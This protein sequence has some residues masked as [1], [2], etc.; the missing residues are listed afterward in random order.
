[1]AESSA[2]VIFA[3][4]SRIWLKGSKMKTKILALC[5]IVL[6]TTV[7]MVSIST[8]SAA[9]GPGDWIT[10]YRIVDASTE[11]LII[12]TESNSG[13]GS[14]I[15]GAQLKVTVTISIPTSSPSTLLNL[16]TAMAHSSEDHFWEHSAS[17][18]YDLGSYNPNAAS[19]TFSQDA[20]TL[21]ITCVGVAIGQVTQTIGSVTLHKSVPISLIYLKDPS[22]ATLDE[23][24]LNITDSVIDEYNTLLKAKQER[25]TSLAG[26]GVAPGYVELY[27]NVITQSKALAADG[28]TE[29]AVD[30]LNGLNVSNEPASATMQILFLPLIVVFAVV[31]GLFGF[32]FWRARGKVSYFK[33]VVEDQIKDLEGLTLR[34]SKIDRTISS[35][36]ASVEDRLK[37]L[38]GM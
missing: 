24:K 17:D 27:Q 21:T 4:Y 34:A 18:G 12:D 6:L 23:V 31:A 22:G 15:D 8:A 3:T 36:L 14:I 1:M 10:K 26:S 30:M 20:G 28:F 5:T 9:L 29:N 19:F 38:V 35:S 32:M 37:R 33:L 2:N 7:F 25:L 13:S 11:Q 16:G